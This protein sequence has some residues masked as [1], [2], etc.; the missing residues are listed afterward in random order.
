M[1]DIRVNTYHLAHGLVGFEVDTLRVKVER[2]ISD[3]DVL[4]R[5]ASLLDSG[6]PLLLTPER[7]TPLPDYVSV[8]V[9]HKDGLVSFSQFLDLDLEG[10]RDNV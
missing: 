10:A 2:V 5:T 9:R 8:G 1:T 4:V 6:T 7:L 3:D